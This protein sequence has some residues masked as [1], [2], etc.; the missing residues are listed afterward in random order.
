[1]EDETGEALIGVSLHATKVLTID[2]AGATRLRAA[3][4][5][6]GVRDMSMF[7]WAGGA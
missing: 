4:G 3:L 7:D 5:T 6:N 2:H 1:L